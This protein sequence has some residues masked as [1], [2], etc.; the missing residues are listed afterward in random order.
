MKKNDSLFSELE[1]I[2][3]SEHVI[4]DPTSLSVYECD[5]AT[6]FKALPDVVVFPDNRTT[7]FS[8]SQIGKQAQRALRCAGRGH[9]LE[10]RHVDCQRWHH[11]CPGTE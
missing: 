8:D 4:T 3:G 5:G 7:D 1:N 11:Y 2:V 6:V 10:W 9:R